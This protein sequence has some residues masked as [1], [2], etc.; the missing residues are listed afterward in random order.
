VDGTYVVLLLL[1]GALIMTNTSSVVDTA[2]DVYHA[3]QIAS[4]Q[5]YP[6]EGPYLARVIH[7][8][9]VWYYVLSVPLFFASSWVVIGAWV[10]FLASLKY[11]L[12]WAIG[13]RLGD[14]RLGLLW[15]CLLALPNWT[16][17]SY[18][19]FSHTNLVETTVLL[20]LYGVVAWQQGSRWGFLLMCLAIG[21][22]FHAHPTV[23]AVALYV[24]PLVVFSL[25]RGRLG[26]GRL[27]LG[28]LLFLVPFLPWI[29]S[30]Q[31]QQW[32]DLQTSADYTASLSFMKNLLGVHHLAWGALV[33]GPF[34]ALRSLFGLAGAA[35]WLAWMG[36]MAI[37]G[38]GLVLAAWHARDDE[39]WQ[40]PAALAYATVVSLLFVAVLRPITQFY[41]VLLLYPPFCGLVAWGW[42]RAIE[43]FEFPWRHVFAWAAIA[44]LAGTVVA[45]YRIGQAGHVPIPEKSL[46]DVR[47]HA[48]RDFKDGIYLSATARA[49]LGDW[50][51]E[52]DTPI[53][54]HG[55]AAL[56][57]EQSYALEARMACDRP[58]VF[59][60]GNGAG[61][62]LLGISQQDAQLMGIAGG[63]R[64]GGMRLFEA[65]SISGPA[66]PLAPPVGDEYPPRG[67]YFG[68]RQVEVRNIKA[69]AG[70]WLAIGNLYDFWM[71]YD[72]DVLLNGM[73]ARPVLATSVNRF[74]HCGTCPPGPVDWSVTISAQRPEF[75]E[76]VT[77]EP[78]LGP[79]EP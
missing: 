50:I 58:A 62:H 30:Q 10:G 44:A 48:L 5:G 54:F 36:L 66:L 74:Y 60:G 24:S 22:G 39:R 14:A 75:V 17:I 13:A 76:V 78:S 77:F 18:L 49:A 43:R 37:H 65:T 6:L 64:R 7:A 73:P 71:P 45:T 59:L 70:A 38:G 29:L 12:A 21:L 79:P 15:A 68:E 61:H 55:F 31:A 34:F 47:E 57:L 23:L 25:I 16:A 67:F 56:V 27:V 32:P 11:L 1:L 72:V 40:I 3:W 2:R 41:M 19:V 35:Q 53:V 28:A 63:E 69:E 20:A 51:C 46:I 33:D 26:W 8:G 4:G 42:S 52:T 9:P